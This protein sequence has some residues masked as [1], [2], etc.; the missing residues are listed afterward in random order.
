M[1]V[2]CEIKR[3]SW[4]YLNPMRGRAVVITKNHPVHLNL[5][6]QIVC[7]FWMGADKH[8]FSILHWFHVLPNNKQKYAWYCHEPQNDP[9]D[10]EITT[11]DD[12]RTELNEWKRFGNVAECMALVH[13]LALAQFGDVV[14]YANV[15]RS[16]LKKKQQQQHS[17]APMYLWKM[18]NA[19]IECKCTWAYIRSLADVGKWCE[20]PSF[21]SKT[22]ITSTLHTATAE[23]IFRNN[24]KIMHS[25]AHKHNND[26]RTVQ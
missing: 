2:K 16:L 21:E 13:Y 9:M 8:S 5:Y 17:T 1:N 10:S 7:T 23:S 6:I 24:W 4:A 15:R 26:M 14:S 19:R 22:W 11:N 3:N 25:H 18:A 20:K 12:A